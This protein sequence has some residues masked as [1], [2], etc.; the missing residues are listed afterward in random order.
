MNILKKL[1]KVI[2]F[3]TLSDVFAWGTYTI[4]SALTGLYLADKLGENTIQFVGIGTSIY[5]LT[6]A[7]TQIPL[8]RITDKYK[9]DKDEILI[10]FVGTILMGTPFIF[11]P[12]IQLPYHYFLLQFVFG[13]GVALNVTT[14]RKLFALNIDGGREGRQYAMYETIISACT[15]IFGVIGGVIA[16]L[17][18]IY[19]DMVVSFAGVFIMFGSIWILF[20]YRYEKRKSK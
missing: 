5:F 20:I 12:Y 3:L 14:W 4:I 7:I 19:F 2:I 17:G 6:R 10:L 11:Y 13:L 8:G 15:A 9:N 18:P 16:N 1:N